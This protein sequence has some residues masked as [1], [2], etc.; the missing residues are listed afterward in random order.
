[1]VVFSWHE[2]KV[3]MSQK[4]TSPKCVGIVHYDLEDSDLAWKVVAASVQLVFKLQQW[5]QN[6][7]HPS[8]CEVENNLVG[9]PGIEVGK[10]AKV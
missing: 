3:G 4:W 6:S 8:K 9:K 2:W 1:M 7:V 5:Q 10:T